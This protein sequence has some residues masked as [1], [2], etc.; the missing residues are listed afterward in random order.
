MASRFA[1]LPEMAQFPAANF[2]AFKRDAQNRSVLAFDAG[3]VEEAYWS[4]IAPQNFSSAANCA[5][6]ISYYMASATGSTLNVVFTANVETPTNAEDLD[7]GSYFAA[8]ANVTSTLPATQGYY[9][10][11]TIELPASLIDGLS[12]GAYFRLRIFRDAIAAFDTASGDCHVLGV[13]FRDA[14]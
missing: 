3:T 2:A 8:G 13:E 4:A 11:A 7:S 6:V 1:F 14:A 9:K 5:V 12:A 10:Q